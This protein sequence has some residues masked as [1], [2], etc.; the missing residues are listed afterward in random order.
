MLLSK[1]DHFFSRKTLVVLMVSV[2]LLLTAFLGFSSSPIQTTGQVKAQV[3]KS[4]GKLPL[5]FEKNVGQT[6]AQVDFLARGSG[7]GFFLTAQGAVLSFYNPEKKEPNV[8]RMNLLGANDSDAQGLEQLPG[9]SNYFVGNDE[10]AWKENVSHFA[11]VKYNNVYPGIDL[12]YYGNQRQIE[13]DF[14]V[15]AGADPKKVQLDLQGAKDITVNDKGELVIQIGKGEMKFHKPFTYQEKNG[16]KKEIASAYAVKDNHI[17]F[18]IGNYDKTQPLVIDPVLEYSTYLGGNQSDVSTAITADSQGNVYMTGFT[19]SPDFPKVSAYQQSYNGQQEVFI[20]KLNANGSALI[21]STYLGGSSLDSAD[22]IALD[23]DENVYISGTTYSTNYPIVNA[24]Q[25]S[26]GG[27]SGDVFLTKLNAS[28]SA[29]IYSTYLGGNGN[30]NGGGLSVDNDNNVYVSGETF[31]TNFPTVNPYQATIKEES[32][33][34][35]TK[36]DN[37]GTSLVYSTYLGGNSQDRSF[38]NA[39]DPNGNVYVVGDTVSTNFPLEA[40]YQSENTGSGSFFNTN[41]FVFKLNTTGSALAYSTYLGGSGSEGARDIAVN[42]AG[43]AFITGF[44][45]SS[46]FPVTANAFQSSQGGAYVTKLDAS[47]S[48]LA[49]STFLGGN[50]GV[51]ANEI[52][53]DSSG[54]AYV[55]GTTNST[56]FPV[57]DAIQATN[58]G[59]ETTQDA[60]VTKLNPTGSALIF[61][62]YLGGGGDDY[63][64]AIARDTAGKVYVGGFTHSTDF[65]IANALYSDNGG[66]DA[67]IA[68]IVETTPTPTESPTI[69]PTPTPAAPTWTYTGSSNNQHIGMALLQSGKVLGAGNSTAEIYDPATGAW[70]NTGSLNRARF[71]LEIVTL[72]NGKVLVAGGQDAQTNSAL[73]SAEL[74]DPATGIWSPT[75][76]MS[77]GRD[78]PI[79]TL[80]ATGKVLVTGGNNGATNFTSAE[81]YDPATATWSPTGSMNKFH[82]NPTATLLANGKVLVVG[83]GFS[84]E[85]YDPA[86]GAWTQVAFLATQRTQHTATLLANDKVLIAGGTDFQAGTRLSSAELYD[87]STNTW[88]SAG[89][90]STV[91]FLHTQTLLSNGLVLLA[92]GRDSDS[93]NLLSSA[94]IYNPSG[95]T[96]TATASMNSRRSFHEAVLLSNGNVLAAWGSSNGASSAELYGV[97]TPTPTSSPTPT[98]APTETPTPTPTATPTDTPTPTPTDTPTPT[99]TPVPTYTIDGNVYTDSN[100][101]GVKDS[102]ETGYE[103]ATLNLNT[104]QTATTDGNGNYSFPNLQSDSYT[105][106]LIIPTG[107]AATTTNPATIP[108]SADTTQNFGIT[109]HNQPTTTANLAPNA[110]DNGE[111]S[112]PVHV[113]LSA[114]A[115][116][117]FTIAN[118]YYQIDGN[119]QQTYS[120]PFEVPGAGLHTITYWSVDNTGLEETPHKTQTFTISST[121]SNAPV[122][123]GQGP[124]T[125]GN[126]TISFSNLTEGGYVYI[127]PSSNNSG[128]PILSKYKI[129]NTFYDIS[130]T[131]TYTGLVTI[132]ITY[133]GQNP[134]QNL[135]LLHY[136]GTA[137]EDITESSTVT[138]PDTNTYVITGTTSTLSPFAIVEQIQP[139]KLNI[140]KPAKVW[141]GLGGLLGSGAKFDLK[142][143]VYKDTTLISSGQLNRFD[144]GLINLFGGFG[145]AKLATIPFN[146]FTPVD[147]SEGSQLRMKLSAR[148]ACTGSLSPLGTARLWYNDSQANS[149]FGA[150]IDTNEKTYYLKDNLVLGTTVGTGPKKTA[151]VQGGA[152]CSPFKSFGTWTITP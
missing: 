80:L 74:Y 121:V 95:N 58:G 126:A 103:D 129:L 144:P 143:E 148:T 45:G 120:G 77:A 6:D 16:T 63:G 76:S 5:S 101:N 13:Y 78:N 94:E 73:A 113:T 107:Y 138:D 53:I 42:N 93:S 98:V 11:K 71:N 127:T 30:E 124:V 48:T 142:A 31:S 108:L 1:F 122:E 26:H 151:D 33:V 132:S 104:G 19:T 100:Q 44:T 114:S 70:T 64:E 32:D 125:I 87:P 75:G 110:L 123:P 145:S 34:F 85:I 106:T 130:T 17:A 140:L 131:A 61:S 3:D 82:P 116:P 99:P 119:T 25:T 102:G 66:S 97:A 137:W 134:N 67:Y 46:D 89:N 51:I 20:T 56:D 55:V 86:T 40:A 52:I 36:F 35:V 41:A 147:F 117:G 139:P 111:Y 21:Y 65:P 115:S 18:E 28:G 57:Q 14:I 141:V 79:V 135:K 88:S 81:L 133:T 68:K 109:P 118:T 59:P 83:G 72:A 15:A 47:G 22:G 149:Q 24:Y 91:R 112:D 27:G 8:L 23:E 50:G 10:S 62:T 54:N 90:M 37:T 84:P 146:T 128:G 2:V 43:N 4:Y 9:K 12:V 150:T 136:N 96:W 152:A 38:S 7:Y 49:Y 60:F 69:I 39:V 92:G 105:E 29:L